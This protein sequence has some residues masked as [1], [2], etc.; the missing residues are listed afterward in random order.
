MCVSPDE[1]GFAYVDHEREVN[2]YAHLWHASRCVLEKGLDDRKGSAWQF[3][4]SIVLSVFSFE[5]YMNHVGH[6]YIENWDDLERLRPM[7]K[8]R[9]LCLTFKIDLGAKGERPLQTIN[10]LIK[11]RN[12]LAH[13]RSITLKPKPKLLAYND[14]DFERQ[15]R[16][17]PVTQ[18]EER[19]RSA[20]FAIRARDDLEAILRAIHAKLPEGEMPLFHFG[21]HTSG[22]RHVGKGD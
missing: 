6:A 2:T 19:I 15:I 3:L 5:A 7:E 22:S 1:R 17:E 8:L 21:F 9:H 20:D 16:E 18:W 12:E 10:D 4:G 14:P 13:G 11:L